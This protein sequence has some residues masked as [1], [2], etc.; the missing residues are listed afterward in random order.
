MNGEFASVFIL[1]MFAHLKV[2]YSSY[3]QVF[4]FHPGLRRSYFDVSYV[5]RKLVTARLFKII[6][7]SLQADR[8]TDGQSEAAAVFVFDGV[9][10]CNYRRSQA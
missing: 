3:S 4:I 7:F 8:L 9:N 10:E 1:F 6:I 5:N 2:L